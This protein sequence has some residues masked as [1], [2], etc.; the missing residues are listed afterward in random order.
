MFKRW[1]KT[2]VVAQTAWATTP[3]L[4]QNAARQCSPE[5]RVPRVDSRSGLPD[6]SYG[7]P[8]LRRLEPRGTRGGAPWHAGCSAPQ[9]CE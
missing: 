5:A 8:D 3:L 4:P 1:L 6:A 2:F 9:Q 7:R